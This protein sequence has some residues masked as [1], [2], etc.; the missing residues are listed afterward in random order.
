MWGNLK[1]QGSKACGY[2]GEDKA[3]CI[4]ALREQQRSWEQAC[5]WITQRK[6]EWPNWLT[7][8]DLG[9]TRQSKR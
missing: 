2:L 8:S 9:E 6:T 5:V 7:W 1:E 3:I 4:S